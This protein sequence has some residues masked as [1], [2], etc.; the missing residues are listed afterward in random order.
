MKTTRF[1]HNLWLG[2]LRVHLETV[3]PLFRPHK[4]KNPQLSK[5]PSGTQA[6]KKKLTRTRI[7]P[8]EVATGS[9][10]TERRNC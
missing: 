4:N 9:F 10:E 3:F 7:I 6:Q 2:L 1:L 5:G 8:K